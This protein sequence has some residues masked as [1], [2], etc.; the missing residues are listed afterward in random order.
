M[1]TTLNKIREHRPCEP[2]WEKLLSALNKTKADNEPV[3]FKYLLDTLG[4]EDAVWCLRT[5]TYKEQC[6][7][8]ADVAESVLPDFEKH[9]NDIAPRKCIQAI[10]DYEQ[11]LIDYAELQAAAKAAAHAAGYA[12]YGVNSAYVAAYTGTYTGAYAAANATANATYAATINS[13]LDVRGDK[14]QEIET[15]FIKHFAAGQI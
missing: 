2:S 15:L 1:N 6:L 12:A 13:T 10:R 8:L 3:S 7:F 5:L 9:S 11:G 4:I 14:W